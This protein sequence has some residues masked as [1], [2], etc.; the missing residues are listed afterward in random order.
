MLVSE[1]YLQQLKTYLIEYSE[2]DIDHSFGFKYSS[3][4]VYRNLFKPPVKRIFY[5]CEDFYSGDIMVIFEYKNIYIV[6]YGNFGSCCVCDTW[7]SITNF[8]EIKRGLEEIFAR[9]EYY[10]S[11]D[12]ISIK[13]YCSDDIHKRFCDFKIMNSEN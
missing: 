2:N 3:K 6:S 13:N 9:L 4:G 5:A 12:E 10:N 7:E 1:E 11:L 8:S